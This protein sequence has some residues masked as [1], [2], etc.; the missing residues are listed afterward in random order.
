MLE[1]HKQVLA[2]EDLIDIW[3]YSFQKWGAAQAD[4]YLDQL[5]GGIAVLAEN[6]R[7]GINCDPIR[8]GYRRFHVKHHMVYYRINPPQID[9]I[10]ILHEDMDPQRHL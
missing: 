9:I 1:I 4:A 7:I 2:E 5:N 10:R 8:Q 6:P 3:F